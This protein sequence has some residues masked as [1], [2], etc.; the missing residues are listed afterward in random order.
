GVIIVG[1]LSVLIFE[2]MSYNIIPNIAKAISICIAFL[3]LMGLNGRLRQNELDNTNYLKELNTLQQHQNELLEENV[4]QR[5]RE[6]S[7]RNAHIE[8][9]MNEL[10]HRVK[11]N[12]QMLY[13]LNS[14]RLTRK[15]DTE[16]ANI[17]KDNISRIK[18]MM[19]VNENLQLNE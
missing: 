4:K 7:Q 15:D 2:E 17:L 6:L 8:T 18:A 11:N 14:L 10:H 16:A 3:F 5:T 12:L 19:L 13:G 1:S 9:L